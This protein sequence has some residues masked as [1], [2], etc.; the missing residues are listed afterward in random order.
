MK[1]TTYLKTKLEAWVPLEGFDGFEVKVA[2]LSR[3]EL[4]KLRNSVTRV[5]F[6]PKTRQREDNIDSELFVKE[7]VK[8][9][10][11]D[12]KGL[13]LDIA[14]KLLPL[15]VPADVDLSQEIEFSQESALD[16]SKNSPVFD[17]WLN[18]VTFDLERFRTR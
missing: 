17:G 18:D 7:F 4:T 5:A 16:L 13:T 8:A 6:N 1:L 12:W 3:E 2:Y 10:V 15:D 14:S 9:V 11:L